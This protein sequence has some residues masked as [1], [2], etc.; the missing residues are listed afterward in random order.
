MVNKKIMNLYAEL[1][2]FCIELI[3]LNKIIQN[4]DKNCIFNNRWDIIL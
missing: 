2:V 1:N 4:R 3:C